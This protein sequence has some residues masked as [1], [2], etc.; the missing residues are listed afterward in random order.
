MVEFAP[1]SNTTS[2]PDGLLHTSS[3][4]KNSGPLDSFDSKAIDY[5]FVDSFLDYDSFNDWFDELTSPNMVDTQ[6]LLP[7]GDA[8]LSQSVEKSVPVIDGVQSNFVRSEDFKIEMQASGEACNNSTD[9]NSIIEEGMSKVSLVLD[10]GCTSKVELESEADDGENDVESE[11]TSSISTSSSSSSGGSSDNEVDEEEENSSSS[12]SSDYDDEEEEYIVEAEGK[13]EIGEL[14]E[15]E[16]RDADGEDE[17]ASAD[18]MVAWDNDGEDLDGDDE[19]LDGEEEEARAEG[20]PITSKNELKVLPPVPQVHAT[21]QPHHQMLPVGV[22]LS[23]LGN[24]VIVEGVEK[25]NPLSEGSILWITE[26]RSPLGL[27]DEIFG[28]VKNPYYSVRYNSES[29]VPLGISGGTHVSFVLEFAD[30]V[31]NNKDLYKK[32]YDASG[33]NDEEVSDDGEFSDDEKELEFKEMQ[34]L[35]KRAMNDNQ[36]INGNKNNGRKKKNNAKARKFVQHTFE[37]ANVPDESKKFYGQRTPEQATIFEGRKFDHPTPQ[38]AKMDM[39]QPSPNQNQQTGPPL[40]PFVY[41]GGCPDL[42]VAEQCFMNE[43]GVMSSF[44]PTYNPYFTPAMNG[45]RPAEMPF[46][47]PQQQNPF[48]PNGLPM[49]GMPWLLQNPAQQM[50]QMPMLNTFVGAAYPQGF[51]GSSSALPNSL[52]TVGAQGIHSGGLQFGQNQNNLQ[53][54]AQ[55]F[56]PPNSHPPGTFSGNRAPQQFNQ[57]SSSKQGRKSHGRGGPHFRGRRGGQQSR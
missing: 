10:G 34:R 8:H 20:G 52:T 29:E 4:L 6:K 39:V 31:L 26:A 2:A 51:V 48:F 47:F 40:A 49:N 56:N 21:L 46:Q 38:Q 19:D 36:Q 23:M 18:D 12:S 43:T 44:P 28:P 32:G 3:K 17:E 37:N 54:A 14:E 27:V 30:Y 57:N 16:I 24:Q 7:E 42:S 25:H 15:G 1:N 13:R 45:I 55:Q 5:S 22:V 35:A 50:P 9:L 33:V 53:P 11:G 41:Q